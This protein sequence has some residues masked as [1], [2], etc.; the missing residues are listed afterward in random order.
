MDKDNQRVFILQIFL[1]GDFRV[2]FLEEFVSVVLHGAGHPVVVAN[3]VHL[4]V[5]GLDELPEGPEHL[6]DCDVNFVSHSP[7]LDF[8]R[9]HLFS[10]L[11]NTN[12]LI[13]PDL[14][15]II[16]GLVM[17]GQ[18]LPVLTIFLEPKFKTN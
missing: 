3:A 12:R 2:S 7:L 6:F 8:G 9:V 4:L 10:F 17:R 13:I 11:F 5:L 14:L 18:R 15:P 1:V 16:W